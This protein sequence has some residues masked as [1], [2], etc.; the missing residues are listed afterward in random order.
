MWIYGKMVEKEERDFFDLF[1][2]RGKGDVYLRGYLVFD[3]F[4]DLDGGGEGIFIF[5]FYF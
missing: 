5:C 1:C 2:L 4:L 3:Y